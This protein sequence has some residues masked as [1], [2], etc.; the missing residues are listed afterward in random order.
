MAIFTMLIRNQ[1]CICNQSKWCSYLIR[2]YNQREVSLSSQ[3]STIIRAPITT[4]ILALIPCKISWS[5]NTSNNNS[6]N[7]KQVCRTYPIT[8]SLSTTLTRVGLELALVARLPCRSRTKTCPWVRNNKFKIWLSY[9]R[10]TRRITG[11][12]SELGFL[13][14]KRKYSSS[15][16]QLYWKISQPRYS[17]NLHRS[18]KS[19]E[20]S[21]IK[22]KTPSSPQLLCNKLMGIVLPQVGV[23][24]D[25][26]RLELFNEII[27]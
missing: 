2:D 11:R 23:K 18:W 26:Q 16:T 17:Y 15:W 27:L 1:E 22:N 21:S 5:S 7:C 20:Q 19:A 3:I 24:M 13:I 6:N 12:N 9:W 10:Q 8:S 25:L 14:T 4:N